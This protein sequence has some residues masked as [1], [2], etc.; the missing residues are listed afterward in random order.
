MI[1]LF[2]IAA[3]LLL[4]FTLI[5]CGP[6]G[7]GGEYSKS[8]YPYD[9]QVDVDRNQMT[10]S[11]KKHGNGAI[12]GYNIYISDKELA[13]DFPGSKLPST[14]NPFNASFFPGDTDPSDGIEHFL[15]EG[16]E[17]GKKFFVSVRVV[18][19]D[20]SL[21]K[22][23]EEILAV[24][25]SRGDISLVIRNQGKNDGYSFYEDKQVGADNE[26][27]DIY[28]FSKDGKDYIDS[29]SRLDSFLRNIRY[30]VLP[31]YG[32][33]EE[34]KFRFKESDLSGWA[35]TPSLLSSVVGPDCPTEKLAETRFPLC[36]AD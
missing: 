19:P 17:N 12:S 3:L 10:I 35:K 27:N 15:A 24:C 8:V 26:S 18:F 30:S 33:W 9:M 32:S 14:V 34:V 36:I 23:S 29:P 28:F 21:S 20:R 31:Y 6:S 25:G 1:R 16:L 11:W 2:R 22:P 13:K 5:T 4:I 7:S